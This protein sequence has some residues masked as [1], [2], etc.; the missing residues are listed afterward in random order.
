MKKDE[1]SMNEK[2]AWGGLKSPRDHKAAVGIRM[3]DNCQREFGV[4]PDR[5]TS[6][7]DGKT[8]RAVRR[9]ILSR[10]T[11]KRIRENTKFS[12][13]IEPSTW[14][15]ADEI[16]KGLFVRLEVRCAG[17]YCNVA[18]Y[19]DDLPEKRLDLVDYTDFI[20]DRCWRVVVEGRNGAFPKVYAKDKLQAWNVFLDYI[21]NELDGKDHIHGD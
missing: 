10:G 6:V 5:I 15:M 20:G 1:V 12:P 7:G 14:S 18:A 8:E 21:A 9:W 16:R 3:A 11:M 17:E 2:E 13:G 19:A 4:F